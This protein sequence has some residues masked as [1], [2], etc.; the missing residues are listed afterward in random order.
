MFDIMADLTST[1]PLVPAS[2]VVAARDSKRLV[3]IAAEAFTGTLGDGMGR[4]PSRVQVLPYSPTTP[5]VTVPRSAHTISRGRF[6][7][8]F[9]PMSPTFSNWSA[10]RTTLGLRKEQDEE[11]AFKKE[12]QVVEM[13]GSRAAGSRE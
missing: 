11:D 8:K 4:R 12:K 3:P 7:L 6:S 10:S 2:A 1:K 5:G 13:S 9:T